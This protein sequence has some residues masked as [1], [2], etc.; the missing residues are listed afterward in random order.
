MDTDNPAL[1]KDELHTLKCE[2]RHPKGMKDDC[3]HLMLWEFHDMVHVYFCWA[4]HLL[5]N[6]SAVSTLWCHSTLL[7]V[8]G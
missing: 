4:I 2:W 1:A 6:L 5:C 8:M 7:K 3:T